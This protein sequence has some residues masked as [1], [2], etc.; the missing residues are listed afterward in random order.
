VSADKEQQ[1]ICAG[2]L[3]TARCRYNS[4]YVGLSKFTAASR[5]IRVRGPHCDS[6]ALVSVFIAPVSST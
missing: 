5:H 1:E 3:E 2:K 6:T 4:T